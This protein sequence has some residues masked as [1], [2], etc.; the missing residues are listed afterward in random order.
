MHKGKNGECTL[1]V[2]KSVILVKKENRTGYN[3]VCVCV[4]GEDHIMKLKS[5]YMHLELAF[6]G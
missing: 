1:R 5:K 6:L 3:N 4:Y 2:S